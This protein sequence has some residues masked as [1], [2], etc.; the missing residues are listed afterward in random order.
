MIDWIKI[1]NGRELPSVAQEVIVLTES[2]ILGNKYKTLYL[3]NLLEDGRWIETT[4]S[5]EIGGVTHWAKV[6]L[7][8][9]N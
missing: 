7:P 8:D 2:E 5:Q 4:D 3:A 9:G 6:N 1:G